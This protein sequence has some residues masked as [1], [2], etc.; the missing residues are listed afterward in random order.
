MAFVRTAIRDAVRNAVRG[1]VRALGAT[2]P[3]RN[4]PDLTGS[5][6]WTFSTPPTMTLPFYIE[7]EFSSVVTSADYPFFIS[8]ADGSNGLVMNPST[9]GYKN[10]GSTTWIP[11][12]T[13][14]W[15]GK[16]HKILAI[17]T[18][19]DVTIS[20]DDGA[21]IVS[22]T[23][24]NPAPTF[25]HVAARGDLGASNYFK[26]QLFNL[27]LNG[28]NYT[29]DSGSTL[30][31][32]TTPA[33]TGPVIQTRIHILGDSFV[34]YNGGW[35][36]DLENAITNDNSITV[37]TDG[38][39]GSTLAE[40]AT[41]FA[42]TPEHYD[43][44]L[45]IMDGGLTDGS[46]AAIAAIDDITGRLSHDAWVWVQPSPQEWIADSGDRIAWDAKVAAIAAH[47]GAEHYVECLSDLQAANDGSANDLQ[48]VADNIV[49]RSLRADAIHENSAG[50]DVRAATI[51]AHLEAQGWSPSTGFLENNLSTDVMRNGDFSEDYPGTGWFVSN[52]PSTAEVVGG[53]FHIVGTEATSRLQQNNSVTPGWYVASFDLEV[54]AGGPVCYII[55]KPSNTSVLYGASK[56]GVPFLF[57]VPAGDNEINTW[58]RAGTGGE[59]YYD[60]ISFVPVSIG[61]ALV[62]NGITSDNWATYTYQTAVT[63]DG[64]SID[65]AWLSADYWLDPPDTVGGDWT[66]AGNGVFT[67]DGTQSTSQSLF[68]DAAT[69]ENEPLLVGYTI[70][71]RSAGTV[72][73]QA[74]GT[75]GT[76]N[77]T[78]D[79][80]TELLTSGST[81]TSN[82]ITADSSFA[83]QISGVSMKHAIE[84][85]TSL[86]GT[87]RQLVFA[88][89]DDSAHWKVTTPQTVS[90][91]FDFEITFALEDYSVYQ[92][93]VSGP[94]HND[95]A[96]IVDVTN[97]GAPRALA[98]VGTTLA[99]PITGTTAVD[100][101]KRHTLAAR[102]VS[103]VTTL[104]VDGVAEGTPTNL[105]LNGSQTI[106]Y[107]GRR[108]DGTNKINGRVFE[109]TLDGDT[110]SFNSG[111]TEIEFAAGGAISA[112][113]EVP[114]GD[115]SDGTTTG[116]ATADNATIS[117]ENGKLRVD[118]VQANSRAVEYGLPVPAEGAANVSFDI[119][120]ISGASGRFVLWARPS[121]TI[122]V[123]TTT[124]SSGTLVDIPSGTTHL[125]IWLRSDVGS[126]YFDN[127][128]VKGVTGT[129][130]AANGFSAGDWDTYTYR[131]KHESGGDILPAAWVNGDETSVIEVVS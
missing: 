79:S 62:P 72:A 128:A 64:G 67:L 32:D 121:A 108:G 45:I 95:N 75:A 107:V 86:V 80:Y 3:S 83:G 19:T 99:G 61:N 22:N 78:P 127:I 126:N 88:D 46:A 89:K 37:T 70:D 13:D 115:F 114:N 111:S 58:L 40:Q 97:T 116:W 100:D 103:G 91:D 113:N 105:G 34:T 125:E 112:T 84:V 2:F 23:Q 31:E 110:W 4:V 124:P 53:R 8:D 17:V 104:Y 33:S 42:S 27:D 39:G 129:T 130:L 10:S 118:G 106:G 7:A 49:P 122:L 98:Y 11:V 28:T 92:T 81:A 71:S 50:Q 120:N 117:V 66:S 15:D 16:K 24:A 69:I 47:V 101:G 76:S 20:L 109:M 96:F 38:V 14:L 6:Y 54:V 21:E 77:S 94:V 73:G 131:T 36:G 90:G 102:T 85:S 65:A 43:S 87:S 1:A 56:S 51:M 60:N 63:H 93:L 25:T 68:V 123:N 57:Q 9:I 12:T 82:G 30:Y 41:R 44:L 59:A 119:E 18:A 74:G 5:E 52:S 55:S 48:D 26:G 29:F 35:S